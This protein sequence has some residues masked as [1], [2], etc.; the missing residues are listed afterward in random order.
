M[1]MVNTKQG[2]SDLHTSSWNFIIISVPFEHWVIYG[3]KCQVDKCQSKIN[4]ILKV[5][6]AYLS[7]PVVSY[8]FQTRLSRPVNPQ[9]LVAFLSLHTGTIS[10]DTRL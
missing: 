3:Y 1:E 5:V 8:I 2:H 4:E 7:L 9:C 6:M 10:L